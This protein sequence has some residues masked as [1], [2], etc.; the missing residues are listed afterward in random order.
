MLHK[1]SY[2]SEQAIEA[3]KLFEKHSADKVIE[4]TK[5][6]GQNYDEKK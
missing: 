2:L 4:T 1:R 6:L 5:G 3:Q